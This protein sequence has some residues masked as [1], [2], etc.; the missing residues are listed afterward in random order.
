[1][2]NHKSAVKAHRQNIKAR[3][4]NR[5][6][7]SRLRRALKTARAAIDSGDATKANTEVRNTVS[8]ID[9]LAGKGIIHPN[10]AARH[11]SRLSR[12]LAA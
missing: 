4:H 9:K 10:A 11:K 2:A 1:M 12:R 5:E 6:F 3:G 7:R 8:L